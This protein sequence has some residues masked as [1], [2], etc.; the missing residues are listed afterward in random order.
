MSELARHFPIDDLVDEYKRTQGTSF[1]RQALA[2]LNIT[3]KDLH[4]RNDNN[5]DNVP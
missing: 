1:G 4:G 5:K 2:Q 3:R